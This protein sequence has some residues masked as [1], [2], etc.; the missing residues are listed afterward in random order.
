MVESKK[1]I[2]DIFLNS[3]KV[4]ADHK[5]IF[6]NK[7]NYEWED[8][9]KFGNLNYFKNEYD[10]NFTNQDAEEFKNAHLKEW[11]NSRH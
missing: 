4:L 10:W 7:F 8:V 6:G 1:Q 2:K 9:L 11:L 5:S 3:K